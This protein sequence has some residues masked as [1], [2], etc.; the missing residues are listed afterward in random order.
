[1]ESSLANDPNAK[2]T[3]K[4]ILEELK[5]SDVTQGRA[6]R[7]I[8][9][10]FAF[11]SLHEHFV[12]SYHFCEEGCG[13]LPF[14][15]L[16]DIAVVA[17]A[18]SEHGKQVRLAVEIVSQPRPSREV[19]GSQLSERRWPKLGMNAEKGRDLQCV[20]ITDRPKASR[21]GAAVAVFR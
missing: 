17:S 21:P 16:R 20:H 9:E 10:A 1:M 12:G 8:F 14:A 2:L 13:L 19:G 3:A 5:T 15:F 11:E 6:G 18:E 4:S 7:K